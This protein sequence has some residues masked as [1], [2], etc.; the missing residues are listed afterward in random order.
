MTHEELTRMGWRR[1]EFKPA[2]SLALFLCSWSLIPIAISILMLFFDKYSEYIF[3]AFV[4]AILL[5]SMSLY[6]VTSKRKIS[7][8]YDSI[9]NRVLLGIIIIILL[10]VVQ[11]SQI[12]FWQIIQFGL[13]IA[14]SYCTLSS[15]QIYANN[16]GS[17]YEHPWS[18]QEKLSE[19]KLPDWNIQSYIFSNHV[20]ATRTSTEIES[21]AWISGQM[22]NEQLKLVLDVF[23]HNPKD[24]FDLSSLQ[25]DLQ[26]ID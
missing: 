1:M 21:I 6:L 18:A 23:G 2:L 15:I 24:E 26:S 8:Q 14:F 22:E 12:M 10:I 5:Q 13:T 16:I 17:S 20:M 19:Q 9:R 11:F 25:I 3:H 4:S 7:L